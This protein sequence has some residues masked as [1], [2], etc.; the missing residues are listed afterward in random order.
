LS[1]L[2]RDISNSTIFPDQLVV[3]SSG[4]PISVPKDKLFKHLEV[5]HVHFEPG[6]QIAQKMIGIKLLR[7]E[8]EW[9]IFLDDDIRLHYQLLEDFV[10]EVSNISVYE[11][12]PVAGI[13]FKLPTTNRLNNHHF[14]TKKVAR[15]F[16]LDSPDR[17]RILRS[18]HPTD[19]LE[20]K[21]PINTEWLNGISA[22]RRD[23]LL[24]YQS[25]YQNTRYASME[26][27][28][29][30][31]KVSRNFKLRYCPSL[32]VD[33][34]QEYMTNLNTTKIFSLTSIWTYYFV[35]S[36]DEMSMKSFFISQVGRSLYFCLSRKHELK[37]RF[38]MYACLK[39][40]YLIMENGIK[41]ETFD[42]LLAKIDKVEGFKD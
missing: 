34:Q 37:R 6:G 25:T 19:Y 12:P 32:N 14:W 38:R 33:F 30:S 20:S 10:R 42:K 22:W 41:R 26:D 7:D 11:K 2:L 40:N 3:V 13:G 8:I 1:T 15:L 27:V 21:I 24:L 17:G 36:H 9:V 18:G 31:Y 5:S 4:E 39:V 28:F 35:R 29:F 16:L 23:T